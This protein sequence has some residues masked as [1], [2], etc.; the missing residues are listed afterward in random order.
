[1]TEQP[2]RR[3]RPP[4][5]DSERKTGTNLTFRARSGLR[6]KLVAE[7]QA[8]GRSISEVIERRIERS[9]DWEKAY[10]DIKEYSAREINKADDFTERRISLMVERAVER[11]VKRIFER[12]GLVKHGEETSS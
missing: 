1:M 3:G 8:S 6:E 12:A 11:A 2:K 4:L 7:A 5:P 10:E 9:F